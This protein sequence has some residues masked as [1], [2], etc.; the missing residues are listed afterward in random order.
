M[1]RAERGTICGGH[2]IGAGLI[3]ISDSLASLNDV[4]EFNF[5]TTNEKYQEWLDKRKLS[6]KPLQPYEPAGFFEMGESTSITCDVSYKQ[7]GYYIMLK[8]TAFRTSGSKI[9]VDFNLYPLEIQYFGVM[10]EVLEDDFVDQANIEYTNKIAHKD[11]V[12]DYRI[13][14][15]MSDNGSSW[16]PGTELSDPV[17]IGEIKTSHSGQNIDVRELLLNINKL[18]MGLTHYGGLYKS[19]LIDSRIQSIPAKMYKLVI[20]K[21]GDSS[22]MLSGVNTELFVACDTEVKSK[23]LKEL[24]TS[25]LRTCMGDVAFFNKINKAVVELTCKGEVCLNIRLA[26]CQLLRNIIKA[27]PSQATPI[28]KTMNLA[29][30]IHLNIYQR[31]KLMVA[32]AV[33]LLQ[34]LSVIPEFCQKIYEI[35][36]NDVSSISTFKLSQAGKYIYMNGK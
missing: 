24:P 27:Y 26:A 11:F 34:Y 13:Q 15:F 6:P 33:E 22:W 36:L 1:V 17:S 7:P 31:E 32:T 2:P 9:G 14:L 20:E 4:N 28:T 16:I 25:Y 23:T 29:D 21:T 30:F 3:F 19:A 5:I 35:I 18:P 8:P 12:T 10:G